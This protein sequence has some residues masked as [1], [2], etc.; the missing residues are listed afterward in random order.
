[1]VGVAQ[2]S[3]PA[4]LAMAYVKAWTDGNGPLSELPCAPPTTVEEIYETHDAMVDLA[5]P[6]L[7]GD[8]AG[9]KMGAVGLVPGVPCFYGPLFRNFFSHHPQE[10]RMSDLC[11]CHTLEAE[12]GFVMKDNLFP[13]EG[14]RQRSLQEVWE[15]VGSICPCVELCGSRVAATSPVLVKLSDGLMTGGVYVGSPMSPQDYSMESLKN[16]Q[17]SLSI[18]GNVQDSGRGSRCPMGGP[19][20]S[21]TW[22]ANYLNERG[23]G[24]QSG[25][26]V[27][28]GMTSKA[29]NFREGDEIIA[30]YRGIGDDEEHIIRFSLAP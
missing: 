16:V 19:V 29:V 17:T 21:L 20:E 7:F 15:A 22:L 30:T 24:L 12:I 27:I 6:G 4:L 10:P 9:Y 23:S 3:S 5:P 2:A 26:L 11:H 8:L 14:G 1:M 28:S 18:N 25:H 13:L